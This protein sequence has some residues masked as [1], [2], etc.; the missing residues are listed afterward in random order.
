MVT[1]VPPYTYASSQPFA[2]QHFTLPFASRAQLCL[3]PVEISTA[4]TPDTAPT[5]VRLDPVLSPASPKVF[6]PQQCTVLSSSNAQAWLLPGS[7]W[8]VRVR[9]V[10]A[11]GDSYCSSSSPMPNQ[12]M[13]QQRTLPPLRPA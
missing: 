4:S 10:M 5:L 7:S 9:L 12:P 11:I 2:P 3:P 1:G 13:P 6:V 8:T